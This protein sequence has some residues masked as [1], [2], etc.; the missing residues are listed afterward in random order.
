[1]AAG[2]GR[3]AIERDWEPELE[4]ARSGIACGHERDAEF[5]HEPYSDWEKRRE[6]ARDER[7]L[8]KESEEEPVKESEG[9]RADAKQPE[10]ETDVEQE[11]KKEEGRLCEQCGNKP[12]PASEC[13]A[14]LEWAT[15]RDPM[16]GEEQGL[17]SEREQDW[18]PSR[19]HSSERC[20]PAEA[21]GRHKAQ[22]AELSWK[23]ESWPIASRLPLL[24]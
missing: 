13:A 24:R 17:E 5:G 9:E 20:A 16:F 23:R 4:R 19:K 1:V 18:E 21:I 12:E 3:A 10:R 11:W 2:I 8:S 15:A 7:R 6:L 22:A 14:Q